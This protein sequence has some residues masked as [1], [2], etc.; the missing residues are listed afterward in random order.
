MFWFFCCE[1]CEIL[2]PQ[3]GIEPKPPA[4][5]GEV[6]TTGLPEKSRV[7]LF[8]R[9]IFLNKYINKYISLCKFAIYLSQV[10][11]VIVYVFCG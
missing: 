2:A 7:T 1:A 6:L 11:W 5:E 9:N 4:L 10:H 8:L 3:T